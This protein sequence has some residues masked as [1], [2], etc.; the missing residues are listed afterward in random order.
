MVKRFTQRARLFGAV[1]HGNLANGF[2]QDVG[3][4][5]HVERQETA[6]FDQANLLALGYQVFDEFVH[7]VTG[8]AHHDHNALGIGV[9]NVVK[10]VVLATGEFGKLVELCLQDTGDGIVVLVDGLPTLE[11]DIRVLSG[12]TQ[13]RMI[14]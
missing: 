12:T 10:Q 7:G 14:R 2:R 5:F 13:D 9:T 4:G 6:H 11:I 1:E 3:E 8:R